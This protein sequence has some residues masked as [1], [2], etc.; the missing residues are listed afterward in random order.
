MV[1]KTRSS[2]SR[3]L[4]YLVP[5]IILAILAIVL[6]YRWVQQNKYRFASPSGM[7]IIRCYYCDG[8]GQVRLPSGE[9]APCPICFGTGSRIVRRYYPEDRLCPACEGMGRVINSSGAAVTCPRC[10]GRGMIRSAVTE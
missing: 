2:S 9:L 10:N 7:Q 4:A 8:S 1:G 5:V 3:P 6:Q